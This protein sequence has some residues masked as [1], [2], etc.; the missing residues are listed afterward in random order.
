MQCYRRTSK[1]DLSPAAKRFPF[2]YL[3]WWLLLAWR[4]SIERF[5]MSGLLWFILVHN[6]IT[7]RRLWWRSF[8][9]YI[10]KFRLKLCYACS[11]SSM[12]LLSLIDSLIDL[13]LTFPKRPSK[14]NRRGKRMRRRYSNSNFV[15]FREDWHSH[16]QKYIILSGRMEENSNNFM[17]GAGTTIIREWIPRERL[18][19]WTR[20]FRASTLANLH[21]S[22]SGLLSGFHNICHNRDP[23]R[24]NRFTDFLCEKVVA[25]TTKALAIVVLWSGFECFQE[26]MAAITKKGISSSSFVLFDGNPFTHAAG[27]APALRVSCRGCNVQFP[28]ENEQEENKGPRSEKYEAIECERRERG[29]EIATTLLSTTIPTICFDVAFRT[30]KKSQRG[31]VVGFGLWVLF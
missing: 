7:D 4:S 8:W 5:F 17:N 31:Q 21:A 6:K 15:G 9:L 29:L 24:K 20:F 1:I 25:P 2:Q 14:S 19:L 18:E 3:I 11:C 13:L 30:K 16:H 22:L 27:A 23:E 28:V 26:T 12:I 10:Y